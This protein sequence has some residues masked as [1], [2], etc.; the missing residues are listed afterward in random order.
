MAQ[1][2]TRNKIRHQ[3]SKALADIDRCLNHLQF[4]EELAGGQSD[5]INET[6]P[7][8]VVMIAE[9]QKLLSEWR[10]TL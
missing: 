5:H 3:A 6:L 10:D 7:A 1:R 2:S 4:L 9:V 8:V